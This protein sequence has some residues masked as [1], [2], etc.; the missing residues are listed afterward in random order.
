MKPPD[1]SKCP[2]LLKKIIEQNGNS[3]TLA[4]KVMDSSPS[5]VGKVARGELPFGEEFKRRAEAALAGSAPDN[6]DKKKGGMRTPRPLSAY[7]PLLAKLIE[8]HGGPT[9]KG[10]VV[11]AARALGYETPYWINRIANKDIPFDDAAQ[12]RVQDALDGKPPNGKAAI[13]PEALADL[14]RGELGIAIVLCSSAKIEAL[15]DATTAMG[16]KWL[17]KKKMGTSWLAICRIDEDKMHIYKNL[18]RMVATEVIT[19]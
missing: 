16:G 6:T 13:A 7:P 5:Y 12:K 15:Y 1:L 2:P 11:A 17:F 4:A 8:K 14:D 9:T 10:A 3:L 19:P 18:M